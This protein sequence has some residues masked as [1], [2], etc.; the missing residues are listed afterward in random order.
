MKKSPVSNSEAK[1]GKILVLGFIMTIAIIMVIIAA[2]WIQEQF[3]PA[4]SNSD[5]IDGDGVPNDEDAF[6]HD[7]S[8]WIDSD[9]DGIGDNADTDDDNDGILDV[10]DFVP[11]ADAGIKVA[12]EMVRVKD[13]VI[14]RQMTG[15][16]SAKIFIDDQEIST[17][18]PLEME[19]DTDTPVNWSIPIFNVADDKAYHP[20]KIELSYLN[21]LG[22][23]ELL[24]I[25]GDD[26]STDE[27][28]KVLEIN[29]YLGNYVGK[30]MKESSDG[31]LDNN[32]STFFTEKDA[33]T[34]F[35]ITTVDAKII[36]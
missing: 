8:E 28:G 7:P 11:R 21:I 34:N 4:N 27:V 18:G 13:F 12:I 6:P 20:I 33:K 23:S 35:I 24:D 19:I 25:D 3:F 29:Y 36:T 15:T 32:D 16:I 31:S 30:E 5:D 14:G 1:S 22:R 26:P 17:F 10:F 2:P 9:G